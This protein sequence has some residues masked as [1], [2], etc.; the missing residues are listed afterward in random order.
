MAAE[1]NHFR[2]PAPNPKVSAWKIFLALQREHVTSRE[3]V[4]IARLILVSFDNIAQY[5]VF[6]TFGQS[7]ESPNQ[8]KVYKFYTKPYR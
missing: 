6:K 2:K 1:K 3:R 7:K 8:V 4:V 5:K